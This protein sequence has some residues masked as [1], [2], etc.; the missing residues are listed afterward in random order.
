MRKKLLLSIG[1]ELFLISR[2]II[3][4]KLQYSF[5]R[6]KVGQTATY[7]GWEEREDAFESLEHTNESVENWKSTAESVENLAKMMWKQQKN[8]KIYLLW[9]EKR[10]T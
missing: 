8:Q 1:F 6:C 10:K 9:K 3:Y 4:E 7:E 2:M 5:L